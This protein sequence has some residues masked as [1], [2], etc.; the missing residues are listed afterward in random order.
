MWPYR[1]AYDISLLLILNIYGFVGLA[2]LFF[3]AKVPFLAFFKIQKGV[4]PYRHA[5]D[6][7][8][9]TL[10]LNIYV[11]IYIYMGSWL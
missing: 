7:P 8:L 5:H 4:W 10:I 9:V 1:Y 3:Q 6:V 2:P 11:Y